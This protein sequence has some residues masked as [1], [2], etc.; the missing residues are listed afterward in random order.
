MLH[1]D[2]MQRG[3]LLTVH[4]GPI[5]ERVCGCPFEDTA[6]NGVPLVVVAVSLPYIAAAITFTGQVL[7]L[8]VRTR[9]FCRITQE[10]ADAFGRAPS[11]EQRQAQPHVEQQQVSPIEQTQKE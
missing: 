10:Y 3:D 1:P 6:L 4:T 5:V 7:T 9:S 8:D 11:R 2:D